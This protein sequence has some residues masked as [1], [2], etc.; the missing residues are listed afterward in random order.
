MSATPYIATW[1]YKESADEASFYPQAGQRGDSVLTHSIYMQIQVPFS[2]L[3]ATI[4][5]RQGCCSLPMPCTCPR[6]CNGCLPCW[7]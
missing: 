7:T 4:I 1:F 3:S 5:P 2:S 6:T